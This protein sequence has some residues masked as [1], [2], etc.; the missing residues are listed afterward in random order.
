PHIHRADLA[1]ASDSEARRVVLDQARYLYKVGHYDESMALS[2]QLAAANEKPTDGIDHEFTVLTNLHLSN[3]SRMLGLYGEARRLTTDSL[4]YM[5]RHPA[6]GTDHEYHAKLRNQRALDLRIAGEYEQALAIDYDNLDHDDP[7]DRETRRIDRNNIAVTYRLLGRFAE[8]H[9]IDR[10]I[11]R[12]WEQEERRGHDPKALLARCNL[13]RD[14][15]GLG[16]Y[17]EA[18]ELLRTTLPAYREVVGDKHSQ[19]LLATRVQVMALRKLGRTSDS[20]SLARENLYDMAL[21]FGDDHEFPLATA[22]SLVNALLAAG[23]LGNA[24]IQASSVFAGCE[25]VFGGT[26]PATL[27]MLVNSAAVLRALGDVR[28]A[29][30]RDERAMTELR[31]TLGDEHPYTLSARHNFAVDLA[32]LG[33]EGRSLDELK[34]VREVS[35]RHRDIT[36]PDHLA[37]EI[38]IAL[39][40]IAIGGPAAGQEAL[41]AATGDLAARLGA[42]H[43]NVL[44]A[45]EKQWL[46]CDIEPPA[47]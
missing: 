35:G 39:A 27:A 23:D 37:C 13:A 17:H 14:M 36:H 8:A 5:D 28:E 1:V 32:R 9:Q 16:R 20:I 30:R 47:T 21:W 44:A 6:F 38:D 4:E 43:P 31:A 33:F 15:Y 3:A 19:V 42:Q 10:D 41:T 34:A 46:E 25:R 29:C 11:V 18:L 12:E 7:N 2:R 24:T 26:H 22:I 40:R 45:K